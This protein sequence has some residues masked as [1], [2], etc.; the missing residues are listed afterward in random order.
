LDE[1]LS[2][3][4]SWS[5]QGG[6]LASD[7]AVD[8]SIARVRNTVSNS[9]SFSVQVSGGTGPCAIVGQWITFPVSA[10]ADADTHK[11]TYATVLTALAL[12]LQVRIYNYSGS[13]CDGASYIEIYN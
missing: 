9:T 12:G 2:L 11:R 1:S 6:S 5:P 10:A 13:A 7:L 3:W 4:G 8:A